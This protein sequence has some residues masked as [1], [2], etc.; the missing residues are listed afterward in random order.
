MAH[1][2]FR[3][4]EEAHGSSNRAFG[5]VFAAVFL[6]IGTLPML[7]G[8]RLRLWSLA[9]SFVFA[10]VAFAA[11]RV[12]APLN[13]LWTRFGLLLHQIVSPIV[14]GIMFFGVVTPM[15]ALMRLAGKDQLRLRFDGKTESY[16]IERRPPGPK[17]DSLPDQF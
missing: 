6:I 4:S 13:K 9:V 11:P 2:S 17:P 12:L 7:V 3:R 16:W 1:E 15:G 14:L 10:A 8:G 5:L